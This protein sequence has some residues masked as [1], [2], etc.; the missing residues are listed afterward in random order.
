MEAK[1][2]DLSSL[3]INRSAEPQ[4]PSSKSRSVLKAVLIVIAAAVLLWGGLF[5]KKWL[6]PRIEVRLATASLTSRAQASAVLAASGYVVAQRKAAVA[7]KGT[8]Q[9]VYLGVQEGDHV[10]KG[11]VIARL[12]D[13]DVTASLEQARAN[14]RLAE[15]DLNDARRSLDRM[16]H[17]RQKELVAQAELDASEARYKRVV[18]TIESSRAAVAAAE[19]ALDNTRI[20]APFDGTVLTKNADIGELVAPQ[21]AAATSRAAVV[22]IADMSSLEVEADVS[23]SN[24]MA[25]SAGQPCEIVLDAYPDKRYQ[26]YVSKMV[27]T[28]DRAKATVLVKV[29]FK[30]YD[31]HVLPEMSARVAF[32]AK[33]AAAEDISSAPILAVPSS[34]VALRNGKKVV[35]EVRNDQAAEVPVVV[36]DRIGSMVEIK[37]G[38]KAGEKVIARVDDKITAGSRVTVK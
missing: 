3:K 38:L 20:R 10:K 8:G 14:L 2:F 29:K 35:Y 34:A 15:A 1:E 4:G 23:E 7:S 18:A 27:P 22:T 11:Q 24:I 16:T 21:A 26:G 28:A 9:L 5:I 19:V 25:I 32:L 30:S 17:L 37:E 31:E 12:E 33:H 13:T 6:E 36:G